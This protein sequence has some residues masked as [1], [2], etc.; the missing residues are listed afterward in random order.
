MI[1]SRNVASVPFQHKMSAAHRLTLRRTIET[2]FQAVDHEYELVDGEQLS[3]RLLA[4]YRYRGVLADGAR[5]AV[6]ILDA[7]SDSFVHVGGEDH[8]RITAHAGGFDLSTPRVRCQ[9]IDE[10]LE[11]ELDYAVS[12]Q[13]GYLR[14]DIQRIGTGLS[15]EVYLHLAA[16]E[17]SNGFA[18][19]DR[20]SA[21]ACTMERVGMLY[22]VSHAARAGETEEESISVLADFVE[23]LVHY[24]T[25][26]REQLVQ[27]HG[28]AI[29]EAAHRALGTLLHA[30]RLS[31][32]EA[33]ELTN[34]L[35]LAAATGLVDRLHLPIACEL[36]M[37]SD[38]SQVAVLDDDEHTTLDQRRAR[39]MQ[40]IYRARATMG[41]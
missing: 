22:R 2:A 3:E 9:A 26:A 30:R 40:E 6:T 28:E 23:R 34:V 20:P 18:R 14:P 21:E 12:L 24:E 41:E 27:R 33:E 8:L 35:R 13:L 29:E 15:A 4:Y 1:L 31:V 16:V 39:L 11:R 37:L 25:S 19:N 38:D 32:S 5:E 17:Q 36:M 10:M 7:D